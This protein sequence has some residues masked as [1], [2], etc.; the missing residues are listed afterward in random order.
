MAWVHGWVTNPSLNPVFQALPGASFTVTGATPAKDL[1][2]ASPGFDLTLTSGVT[3]SGKFDGEFRRYPDFQR[4]GFV[5][6]SVVKRRL[7]TNITTA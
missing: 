2:L 6:L 7:A 5:A 4:N 3:L 1:L